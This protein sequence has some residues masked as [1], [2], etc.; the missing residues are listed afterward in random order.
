MTHSDDKIKYLILCSG[1]DSNSRK[2]L[3]GFSGC[4]ED[5]QP[6]YLTNVITVSLLFLPFFGNALSRTCFPGNMPGM[7]SLKTAP[8]VFLDNILT[9]IIEK[10]SFMIGIVGK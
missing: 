10:E 3:S 7:S 2:H 1:L 9:Q 6:D 8:T 4:E 5:S